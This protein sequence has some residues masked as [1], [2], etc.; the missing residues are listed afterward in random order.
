MKRND[1]AR[2]VRTGV[3][4]DPIVERLSLEQIADTTKIGV[5]F[6]RAIEAEKFDELPGGIFSTSY[7]RQYARCVGCN[8]DELLARFHEQMGPKVVADGEA[9]TARRPAAPERRSRLQRW[10]RR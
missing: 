10:F 3:R 1:D 6:L 8:E 4:D 7:L 2:D 5:G 9:T